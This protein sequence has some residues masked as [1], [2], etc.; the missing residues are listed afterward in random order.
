MINFEENTEVFESA[1]LNY[2]I[3]VDDGYELY[4]IENETID[5]FK[6]INNINGS[7]FDNPEKEK[8]FDA[9]KQY[10]NKYGKIPTINEIYSVIKIQNLE[11]DFDDIESLF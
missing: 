4:D 5:R 2:I 3:K 7:F 8:V 11:S 6:V 1:I 9:I 10:T